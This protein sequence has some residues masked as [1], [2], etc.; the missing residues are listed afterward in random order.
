MEF[1][2]PYIVYVKTNSNGYIT[3]VDSS[4]FLTDIT[5]WV[6]IDSGYGDKYHHAQGNYFPEPIW[7]DG[8]AYRYK[9]VDG[10]PV[11][12]TAEE[13]A[14]QEEA[15]KPV[16]TPTPEE[17]IAELEAENKTLTAQVDALSFQLDFQEECLVE[18]AGIIYA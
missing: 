7:T 12:C 8:G 18:M 1:E 6:E 9:L 3:A 10:K 13:I 14:A 17:R 11:E 2:N 15:N 16:P 4:A 5:G